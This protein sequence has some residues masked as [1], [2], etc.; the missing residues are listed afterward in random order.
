MAVA[1][2]APIVIPGLH[3]LFTIKDLLQSSRAPAASA[4]DSSSGV[5]WP[6]C[7]FQCPE[8]FGPHL[9]LRHFQIEED[10]IILGMSLKSI[11][12]CWTQPTSIADINPTEIHDHIFKLTASGEM[13][14]YENGQG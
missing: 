14:P 4:E 6:L 13:Q 11:Q 9:I 10:E 3:V 5:C 7:M 12:G 1:V 8:I 2:T